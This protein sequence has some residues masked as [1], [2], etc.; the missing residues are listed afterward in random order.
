MEPLLREVETVNG[1]S[2]PSH[3]RAVALA[4]EAMGDARLAPA[5]AAALKSPML[6]GHV[7]KGDSAIVPM[8]GFGGNPEFSRCL[9]ELNVA[10]ALLA[11]G[12]YEGLARQTF[13]DYAE[14][15]RGVLAYHARA[16]LE[17]YFGKK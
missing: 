5:L 9:R 16:V 8:S 13:E 1:T 2:S 6:G 3:V 12:D 11:C 17:K 7:R 4:C 10:R 14:D 15:G